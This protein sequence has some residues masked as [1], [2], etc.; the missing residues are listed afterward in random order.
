MSRLLGRINQRELGSDLKRGYLIGSNVIDER[1][2]GG[3]LAREP[4]LVVND[5][6]NL[7]FG[8][9]LSHPGNGVTVAVFENPRDGVSREVSRFESVKVRIP[10]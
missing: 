5:L 6:Y 2:E 8:E 10:K 1:P 3:R 9:S 7:L 4:S